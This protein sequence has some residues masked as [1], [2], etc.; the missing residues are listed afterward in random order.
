M[1]KQFQDCNFNYAGLRHLRLPI[2]RSSSDFNTGIP[3]MMPN[4]TICTFPILCPPRQEENI[5]SIVILARRSS[6][7]S[8]N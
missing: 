5:T 6:Q 2:E 7:R 8:E 3:R 4:T 1:V